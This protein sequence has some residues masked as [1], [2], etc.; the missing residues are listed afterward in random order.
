MAQRHKKG[1]NSKAKAQ[2][3][4]ARKR[5]VERYNIEFTNDLQNELIGLVQGRLGSS[6]I[7]KFSTKQS[8]RVTDYVIEREGTHLRFLYDRQRK[9]IVSALPL[10]DYER[11]L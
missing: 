2:T 6:A 4:H 8:C 5:F 1:K 9:N 11:F 7:I 3:H 10:G